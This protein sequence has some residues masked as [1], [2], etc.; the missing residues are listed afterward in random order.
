MAINKSS[1][2]LS[3]GRLGEVLALIQVLAYDINTSR[4][5]KG[6]QDELKKKPDSAR[7]WIELC[8]SHQELFRVRYESDEEE[9]EKGKQNRVSL[10]SRYVLPHKVVKGKKKRPQLDPTIVN[11]LMEIAIEIHDR[12]TSRS[13]RW[14]ILIPMLV[15]IVGATASIVAALIKVLT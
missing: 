6:L 7:S 2:Y 4:S 12:Q 11:K 3:K 1:S 5:E 13:E 10:V 14:K 15:A 9:K 8:K